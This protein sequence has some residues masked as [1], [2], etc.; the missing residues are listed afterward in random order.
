MGQ[1]K[2]HEL[3][4]LPMSMYHDP[5]PTRGMVS[6]PHRRHALALTY[7]QGKPRVVSME[8]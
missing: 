3:T 5:T 4:P 6:A 1:A 8:I 7:S 2:S